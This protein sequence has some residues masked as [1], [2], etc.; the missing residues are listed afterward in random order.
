MAE[1]LYDGRGDEA[2]RTLF[3]NDVFVGGRLAFNDVGGTSILAG[4]IVDDQTGATFITVEAS[5][6][7]GDRWTIEVESLAFFD[8]PPTG[9]LYSVRRDDYVQLR[10]S[11]FF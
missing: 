2:P 1:Y 5:R 8:V 4:A 6:R 10:L 7:L 11:R 9:L 3:E